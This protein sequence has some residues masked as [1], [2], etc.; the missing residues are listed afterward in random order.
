MAIGHL[1]II[2]AY[3]T[4]NSGGLIAIKGM[5]N[6]ILKTTEATTA[7][8]YQNMPRIFTN[9]QLSVP[10]IRQKIPDKL[11]WSTEIRR[12][13]LFIYQFPAHTDAMSI[14]C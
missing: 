12:Y 4:L 11:V 2:K 3:L 1:Y 10:K 8:R 6:R 7:N 13:Y 14:I 9:T 5:V